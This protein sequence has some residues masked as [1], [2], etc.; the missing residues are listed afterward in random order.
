[1]EGIETVED[2]AVRE[3]LEETGLHVHPE[4]KIGKVHYRCMAVLCYA[5][6]D[7]PLSPNH[8]FSE[9]R[10][11]SSDEIMRMDGVLPTNKELICMARS[12]H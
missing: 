3:C 1:M 12:Q 7:G 6:T 10:W 2:A 8:E 5:N 4:E 9:L 11:I